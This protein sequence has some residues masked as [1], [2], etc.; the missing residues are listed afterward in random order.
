MQVILFCYLIFIGTKQS[1]ITRLRII[2]SIKTQRKISAVFEKKKTIVK[3]IYIIITKEQR[4]KDGVL[5]KNCLH[6]GK[7]QT[8]FSAFT[9]L[10]LTD[11]RSNVAVILS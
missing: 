9:M 11:K 5:K 4:A 1:H 10:Y 7:F 2:I 3:L 8:V 6:D